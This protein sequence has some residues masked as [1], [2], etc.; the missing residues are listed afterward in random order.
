MPRNRISVR[1]RRNCGIQGCEHLLVIHTTMIPGTPT[2]ELMFA[3]LGWMFHIR[4]NEGHEVQNAPLINYDF[5]GIDTPPEK[6]N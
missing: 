1:T 4:C 6:V 5:E 3:P 2:S